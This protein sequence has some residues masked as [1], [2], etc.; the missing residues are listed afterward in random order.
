MGMVFRTVPVGHDLHRTSGTLKHDS[1]EGDTGD[2]WV[3]LGPGNL[4]NPSQAWENPPPNG[5]DFL[6][7]NTVLHNDLN[8][9]QIVDDSVTSDFILFQ[10]ESYRMLAKALDA[11]IINTSEYDVQETFQRI[12]KE[13]AD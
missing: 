1:L 5:P 6:M 4:V 12:V 13:I 10:Q 2:S 9:F 3:G 8:N 11:N 7:G